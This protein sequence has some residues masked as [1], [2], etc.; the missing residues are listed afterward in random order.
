MFLLP[1]N[2]MLISSLIVYE[3]R[4]QIKYKTWQP[5]QQALWAELLPLRWGYE[6]NSY[7]IIIFRMIF[8]FALTIPKDL[9]LIFIKLTDY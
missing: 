4:V 6:Q 7:A 1:W 5:V 9:D 8:G 3:C 2:Q